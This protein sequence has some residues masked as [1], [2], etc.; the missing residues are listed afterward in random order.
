M[1]AKSLTLVVL[2]GLLATVIAHAQTHGGPPAKSTVNAAHA[3]GQTRKEPFAPI[4][5]HKITINGYRVYTSSVLTTKEMA[6]S[7]QADES[8]R[9]SMIRLFGPDAGGTQALSI[10]PNVSVMGYN[11]YSET[12]R[13]QFSIEGIKTGWNSIPGDLATNAITAELDGVPLNGLS[14]GTAWHSPEIPIGALMQGE[15]VIVG[16]GN[17]AERWYDSMGGTVDFV[18]VQP[19][20]RPGGKLELAGGS[21]ATLDTSGIYNT[22]AIGGWSTVFGFAYSHS[23]SFRT[24]TSVLPE[25]TEEAYVKTRKLFDDGSSVSFAGYYERNLE[26]RPNMI[27]LKPQ[28]LLDIGGLD[29]GAPYSQQ[30][31]GFYATLPRSVWQK[32]E[33]VQNYMLWSHAHLVLSPTLR[34]S[35]LTWVR[36]GKIGHFRT[37]NFY[38]TPSSPYYGGSP[39]NVEYYTQRSTTVGDRLALIERFNS[40]D[41]LSFGGYLV[42]DISRNHVSL[43]SSFDGSSLAYP[44]YEFRLFPSDFYWAA[45]IQDDF[46]PLPRL[47]IVLG[48]RIVQFLTEFAN[49]GQAMACAQYASINNGNCPVPGNYYTVNGKTFQ[50]VSYDTVPDEQTDFVRTEPSLGVNYELLRGLHV[51]G[52]YATTYHNPSLYNLD[53]YPLDLATLKPSRSEEYQFG[54]RYSKLQLGELHHVYASLDFFHTLLSDETIAYSTV[55]N[56]TTFFFGYGSAVYRGLNLSLRADFGAHWSGFA[57]FGYLN[58]RWNEFRSPQTVTG[59]Q[60]SGHGLPVSNS[61]QETAN[62]GISYFFRLPVARMHVTFWD[63]YIGNR[64]LFDAYTFLPSTAKNPGYNLLNLSISART[65]V[66][67]GTRSSTISLQVLNLANTEYNS[68][69]YI[70]SGGYFGTPTGGYTIVNPGAPRMIFASLTADF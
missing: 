65:H 36:I 52:N 62:G 22:G 8:V 63:Q 34:L 32:Q 57:S 38:G 20:A 40:M 4:S 66:I 59:S 51:Y 28:P 43:Y 10:L 7:S 47:K 54:L 44:Q 31:S 21:D 19:S 26:Y 33:L 53:H 37:V 35:N 67:P 69:A 16:P 15:N 14:Q 64:Y 11:N 27:P 12:G 30:T 55:L 2:V 24:S 41:T 25:Q 48:F 1:K 23:H 39:I 56:P 50:F 3:A 45:F 46:R 70:T 13:S 9:K 29:I 5:L 17:P 18:P 61:P 60:S 68:T 6:D 42:N 58:A 49:M